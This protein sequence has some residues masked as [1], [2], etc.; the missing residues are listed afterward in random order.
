MGN[1]FLGRCGV[2]AIADALGRSNRLCVARQDVIWTFGITAK[3]AGEKTKQ[4]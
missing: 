4:E 3:W 1:F 2:E